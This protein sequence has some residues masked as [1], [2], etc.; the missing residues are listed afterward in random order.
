MFFICL[1]L[2]CYEFFSGVLVKM[3]FLP[4]IH[5]SFPSTPG[6]DSGKP[7]N[8]S[9]EMYDDVDILQSLAYLEVQSAN[10]S[11]GDSGSDPMNLI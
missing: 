4:G 2:S 1:C 8:C 5:P 9:C 10:Q 3:V 11:L 7:W 6:T